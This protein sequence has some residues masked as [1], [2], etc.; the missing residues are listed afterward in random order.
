VAALLAALAATAAPAA[1]QQPPADQPALFVEQVD[2]NV[3]NVE[4]FVTD[5]QGNRVTGLGRDDFEL[6]E[7]G[8]PVEI[9]NFYAIDWQNPLLASP[10]PGEAPG[11]PA[12]LP[13]P[14]REVPPDQRLYLAVYVD[15]AH[16]YPE[17]RRRLLADLEGFLE[18]RLIEGDAVM[19]AGYDRTMKVIQPFTGDLGALAAGLGRL[20]E[21]TAMGPMH[22]AEKRQAMLSMSIAAEQQDDPNALFNAESMVRTYVQSETADAERSGAAIERLVGSLA[23]LP[24]RKAVL[25]VSGGMPQRPGEELYLHLENLFGSRFISDTARG[26]HLSLDTSLDALKSDLTHVYR[27]VARAANANQVTLY[28]LDASGA[29]GHATAA[30]ELDLRTVGAG[31]A[32]RT[33]FEAITALN[34]AEP[35]ISLA[36][37]TGGTPVINTSNF[38]DALAKMA[39]DF[40]SYYSLGYRAPSGGDGGYHKIDVR[41]KRPGLRLR[42]RTGYVDRPIE[43]RVADRTLSSLML[44]LGSNPLSVEVQFGEPERQRKNR[45]RLP[46]LVRVPMH[47]ITLLPNGDRRE[48]RLQIFV[49]VKDDEGRVSEMHRESYPVTVPG[50]EIE[51]ALLRDVGYLAQLELRPGRPVVAVGVWDELSGTESFVQQRVLV[52]QRA[53]RQRGS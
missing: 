3:V 11:E 6:F 29:G 42:H 53:A 23:G 14:R 47:Q 35:M 16:L 38:D 15:N 18:D 36:A 22:A 2:V 34:L 31:D 1:A 30:A 26:D 45:W 21:M 41:L 9:T 12:P 28:T 51:A 48:G 13:P 37:D 52:G 50:D 19:L 39:T 40:D 32:G 33:V 27:D 7:D 17:P 5:R 43:Q 20:G 10:R 24:G 25:F 8:E 44:D 49:V 46:V 4:V